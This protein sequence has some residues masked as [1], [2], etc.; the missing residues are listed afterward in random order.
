MIEVRG[1]TF[2]YPGATEPALTKID[3]R[4]EPGEYVAVSGPNGSGKSTLARLLN[5]LLRP[6]EG[7]ITVDGLDTADDSSIVD[8]RRRV[9]M[10]FQ[11]PDNQLVGATVEDDV[12]FGLENLGI[13]PSEIRERVSA[14][15]KAV[16]L[17]DLRDRPPH[18]LSG[19]QKQRV[20]LAG[21]LVMEP[22]YII[23][24]EATSML[25][26][27]S[28]EDVLSK[29]QQLRRE[30]E[31]AVVHISHLMEEVLQADRILVLHQGRLVFTG[32]PS[33]LVQNKE[34][35]TGVGFKVPAITTLAENLK[36]QGLKLPDSNPVSEGEL[37]QA[38]WK[39]A[40]KK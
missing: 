31:L 9:G 37:A 1:A 17:Q 20:A 35:F 26:P 12:A 29:V 27:V 18:R 13:K 22:R 28:R 24:D 5:A 8:I 10:V 19:G 6:Q 39:L 40:L 38:L 16:D 7:R 34:I 14:A 32:A 2:T 33:A 25:D 4:I 15:L 3:L 30:K 11:D 21:I 23:L 36:R